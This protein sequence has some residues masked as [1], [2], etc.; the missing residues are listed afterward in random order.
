VLAVFGPRGADGEVTHATRVVSVNEACPMTPFA[1]SY[2]GV[3]VECAMYGHDYSAGQIV[4]V[5]GSAPS[6]PTVPAD[7]VTA[8]GSGLDPAVSPAYAAL[9]AARVAAARGISRQ[10]VMALID[11]DTAG[12]FLGFM[13]EPAVNVLQLNL[14]LDRQ[15]PFR[16]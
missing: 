14:D 11:D 15:Y 2:D 13:G 12:R 5:R 8:S 7:A 1:A 10:D 3:R 4:P 16:G 9:Q 6:S